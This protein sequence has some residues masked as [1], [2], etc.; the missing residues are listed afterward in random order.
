MSAKFPL[1]FGVA[2]A[3]LV[4]FLW[5]GYSST[6]DSRLKVSG[7]ILKVRSLELSPESTLVMLDF[8]L[9]NE[10][11]VTFVLKEGTVLWTDASGKEHEA[12]H[13]ARPDLDRIL[14]YTQQAGPKYN[15]MFVMRE[16]L[17]GKAMLDRMTA[18]SIPVSDAAFAKRKSV[19]LKLTD[20]DGLTFELLERKK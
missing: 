11:D 18:G 5:F 20:L 8:R 4:L 17:T 1:F 7:E 9:T 16:K 3:A 2:V 14:Q 10:S 15:E 12:T 6:S 13:V 19:R